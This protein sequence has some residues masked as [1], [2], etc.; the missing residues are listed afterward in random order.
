MTEAPERRKKPGQIAVD[1]ESRLADFGYDQELKRDWSLLHNFGVSFSII[2]SF[3]QL[4]SIQVRL[5]QLLG[6]ISG[7]WK[8][9][10]SNME[11]SECHHWYH[12]IVRLWSCHRWTWSHGFRVDYQYVSFS[13]LAFRPCMAS[14]N[15]H[16]LLS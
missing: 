7:S 14:A 11:S 9:Q 8:H 10:I 13:P 16:E 4:Q 3:I 5:R 15:L 2:V 6:V 1:D 12:D